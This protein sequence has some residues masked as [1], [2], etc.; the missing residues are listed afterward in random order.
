MSY[1]DFGEELFTVNGIKYSIVFEVCTEMDDI[2]GGCHIGELFM[3]LWKY[4]NGYC[5]GVGSYFMDQVA[6]IDNDDYFHFAK[7]LNQNREVKE[8]VLQLFEP[9]Q[10]RLNKIKA[11]L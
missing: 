11:F 6:E 2:Y 1:V 4:E 5:Y 3:Y 8:K 7:Y 9:Y 10:K